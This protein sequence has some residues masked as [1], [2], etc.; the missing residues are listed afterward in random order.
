MNQRLKIALNV[1]LWVAL[2]AYLIVAAGYCSRQNADRLCTGL[3]ITV[4]DSNRLGLVTRESVRGILVN[5]RMRLTGARLDSIN[6]LAVEQAIL[7]SPAIARARV[8]ASM[9]G[10]LNI[11]VEQREP[12]VRVQ[13]ENGYRFYLSADGTVIPLQ[14]ARFIDLPIVT[15]APQLPF[16]T[17]FAGRIPWATEAEKKSDEKSLFLWNL[18][19]F[20][21]Y[22]QQDDFWSDQ[23]VQINVLADNEVELIPRLGRSVIRLGGLDEYDAKLDKL[24]K[25]YTKGLRYEGWDKYATI[26]LRYRGQVVCSI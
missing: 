11:E 23:V 8:Y 1:T 26:D 13:T 7:A 12:I 21:E 9:D 24:L 3:N 14:T 25:F 16:G 18:I 15:G 2:A 22:L 10:K 17:E 19:N 20:V 5:Q 4:Q 6:L